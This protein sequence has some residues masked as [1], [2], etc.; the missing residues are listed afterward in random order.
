MDENGLSINSY[1]GTIN[2]RFECGMSRC[3]ASLQDRYN[4]YVEMVQSKG[5]GLEIKSFD[6]WLG[7]IF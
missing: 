5:K 3:G 6:E 4:L 1:E 7:P 2:Q